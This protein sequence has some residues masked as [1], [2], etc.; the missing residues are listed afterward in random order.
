MPKGRRPAPTAI[1]ELRGNYDKNPQ[2]KN[3]KEPKPPKGMPV[4]PRYLDRVAKH[5]WR[6]TC[7]LLDAMGILSTAD[8]SG[9]TLYC[10]TFSE[11][12]K[13]IVY[14]EKY[15]AWAVFKDGK[16]NPQTTRNEWDRV[17][18]RTADACRKW[19]V[20][21]GLTPSARTRLQVTEETKDEFDVF[22]SRYTR[23]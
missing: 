12:R 13:A 11:W 2:R 14:C 19:L 17:R 20:E 3:R 18:E 10:Q 7:K 8:R 6:E 21:F 22:L 1:Q 9:L 16:D 23:N 5:E 4:A 15:G